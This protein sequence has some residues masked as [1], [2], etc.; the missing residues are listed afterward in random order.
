MKPAHFHEK[1]TLR[2]DTVIDNSILTK[3][4]LEIFVNTYFRSYS[5][6]FIY[7]I[8]TVIPIPDING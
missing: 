1:I 7:E 3:M 4:Y 8:M 2:G 5:Y 6:Q